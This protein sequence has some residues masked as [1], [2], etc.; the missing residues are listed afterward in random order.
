MHYLF[1]LALASFSFGSEITLRPVGDDGGLRLEGPCFLAGSADTCTIDTGSPLSI[2]SDQEKFRKFPSLEK[3]KFGSVGL[4]LSCNLIEVKDFAFLGYAGGFFYRCDGM[5]G[6]INLVGLNFFQGRAVS[7]DFLRSQIHIG[8]PLA[9]PTFEL[10]AARG[11]ERLLV[12]ASIGG[13]KMLVSIDTGAPVT[14]VDQA[15][16]DGHP[17]IFVESKKPPTEMMIRR[18]FRRF[19]IKSDIEVGG[20]ILKAQHVYGADI[21]P[22]SKRTFSIL[23]G[24]NHLRNA[25]WYFDFSQRRWAISL[26]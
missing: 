11:V 15:Y 21:S 3:R 23:L 17:E 6:V 14:L 5:P 25:N 19:E 9:I 22:I 1:F 26:K 24:M 16:I 4:E 8:L 18:G 10:P 2:V 12:Q 13:R 7:F 20:V